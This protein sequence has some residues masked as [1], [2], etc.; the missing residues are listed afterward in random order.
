QAQVSQIVSLVSVLS[1]SSS[2]ADS[3]ERTEVGRG[4][5]LLKAALNRVPQMDSIYVGY[6][7]GSWLQVQRMNDLST[8]QRETLRAPQGAD[9]A[10]SLIRPTEHGDL[11]MRQIF[12]DRNGNELEQ[13]DLWSYGYDPRKRPWYIDT[14][15][16]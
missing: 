8:A 7:K 6:D 11:P 10:I 12:E 14:V 2:L 3:E 16:A 9:F 13:L 1:T 15:A 5:P 4:I